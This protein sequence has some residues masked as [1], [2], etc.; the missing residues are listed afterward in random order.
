MDGILIFFFFLMFT[1]VGNYLLRIEQTFDKS[2]LASF[3]HMHSDSCTTKKLAI[4]KRISQ[5]KN[6]QRSTIPS[7][8]LP[9]SSEPNVNEA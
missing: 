5:L 8:S 6:K 1:W 2:T 4:R 9:C 3:F 7:G